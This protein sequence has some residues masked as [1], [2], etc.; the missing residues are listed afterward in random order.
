MSNAPLALWWIRRDFR[1]SDHQVL[2]ALAENGY[3]IQ[4]V[5]II[6]PHLIGQDADKRIHFLW[7]GLK[8]LSRQI[9]STGGRLIVRRGEPLEQLQRLFTATG[10]AVIYAEEDYSPYARQRDQAVAQTLPLRRLPGITLH[11]P[12]WIRKQNGEPLKVYSAFRNH[13]QR[14]PKPESILKTPKIQWASCANCDSEPLPDSRAHPDFPAGEHHAQARLKQFIEDDIFEYAATRNRVD[15]EQTSRLS[16][17]FHLGM[18]SCGQAYLSARSALE[19]ALGHPALTES[20]TAWINELIWRE[21]YQYILYHYPQVVQQPFREK[22]S[23]IQW[24]AAEDELRAWKNGQTG[25]PI[26]DA[27][28]RQLQKTGW[29]HNRNRMI[30]ASF[31]VKD[32]LINWQEGE[33]HFMRCLIDADV[34]NNNGGWQWVA[35]VGTDA[36]P[37]F[38]IFNPTSQSQKADPNGDFIRQW[39]PEL[40]AVPDRYIHAPHEMPPETQAQSGCAIGKDYPTPIVNH[41]A[42][43]ERVLTA[44]KQGG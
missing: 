5:F 6:D 23:Q 24:R 27:A 31:L 2:S 44:Y 1:L 18:I 15:L 4:P 10:A 29:M 42:A 33:A 8:I 22:Y 32:L 20:V 35:G 21:F 12:D 41:A 9:E 37:Y 13:W 14:L 16:P 25:F 26:V 19:N 34:A 11:S 39:L 36:A 28:M 40:R 17:Y 7:E 38:R 30:V 43:R 3:Q